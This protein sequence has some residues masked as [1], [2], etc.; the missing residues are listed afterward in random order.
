MFT[1]ELMGFNPKEQGQ[2]ANPSMLAY[3]CQKRND[4][5]PSLSGPAPGFWAGR[6]PEQ[7]YR[8]VRPVLGALSRGSGSLCVKSFAYQSQNCR[9]QKHEMPVLVKGF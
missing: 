4:L 9:G 3:H 1:N 8:S 7:L 5:S 6:W 2:E